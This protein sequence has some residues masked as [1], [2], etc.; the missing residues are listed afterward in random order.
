VAVS[1]KARAAAD[2]PDA[3]LA[4]LEDDLNTP[5]A[6]AELFGLARALNKATDATTRKT[7]A[8][9]LYACGDLIGVLGDDPDAW[10]AGRADGEMSA[11]DIEALIAERTKARAARDFE[12]ADAVRDQ[13]A[14]A[15]ISIEDGDGG[16]SWRRSA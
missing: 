7:L 11:A 3:L 5:K 15:G 1:R 8:A 2:I 4:A 16:T 6:L 14:A 10:F 13:L 12:A 9:Q